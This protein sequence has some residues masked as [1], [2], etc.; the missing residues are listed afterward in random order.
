[1]KKWLLR[2][3]FVLIVIALAIIITG[4]LYISNQSPDY[5]EQLTFSELSEPVHVYYDEYAIPHIYANEI[6][7][8]YLAFGYI[9]AKDR[10]WQMELLR[11]IAPG[12]LSE[13]FGTRMIETDKFFRILGIHDQSIREANDFY[14]RSE[15]DLRRL[16]E[17]YIKG[18]NLFMENGNRPVEYRILG[19]DVEPFS[20][21]DIYNIMGYM[22]FSFSVAH[23]TE[24]IADF[25][26]Q[27]LGTE[28]L[29]ELDLHIDSTTTLI[30]S[31]I[32]ADYSKLSMHVEDIKSELPVPELIGS[33]SWVIGPEKSRTGS[34]L[35][36]N[37]PHIG[38]S[39]PSVWYEAHIIAPGYEVYGNHIAGFPIAQI[40]HN[41]H[42]AIGLTMF[43]N[44]D[45]DY[46]RETINPENPDEYWFD[47]SWRAIEVKS[48]KIAV[49][50]EAPVAFDIRSTHHGPIISDV[51]KHLDA[52]EAISM[53]WVYKKLP[54]RL[55]EASYQIITGNTIEEVRKGASMIH[56][57]GLNV[58]YGDTEGNIAWWASARLPIR[59]AHVNSKLILDGSSGEDEITEYYSFDLNPQAINPSSGFVYSANNQ[60]V[61]TTG[62]RYPG[63]YLPEDRARRIVQLLS[64]KNDWTID[65]VKQMQLD[66]VSNNVVEVVSSIKSALATEDLSPLARRGLDILSEWNGSYDLQQVAPTI[67]TKIIFHIMSGM[68]EDELKERWK[69][70]NGTFLMKR[71]IQ[72]MIAN[73]DSPWWD[74]TDTEDVERRSQIISSA[75]ETTMNEIVDQLGDA[76][77][78]WQWAEVHTLE[79]K[80]TFDAVPFLKN[81]FNVGP[82]PISGSSEV[83]NNTQFTTSADGTYEVGGGPSCRRAI[84]MTK[85]ESESWN[86]LPTGQS[87]NVFSP[88][89]KD[90]VEM[91]VNGQFRRQLMNQQEI[92]ENHKYHT[93]LRPTD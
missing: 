74:N 79:S 80:H 89:Y 22:S 7:D 84:E 63:Y 38:Y 87:G 37:D 72:P 4:A 83:I 69:T 46:Y 45:V 82:F 67:Y 77:D 17:S 16:V 68:M 8:A 19:V 42:H 50:D 40:G 23:K 18:V 76:T 60:S 71:S 14:Q 9:H 47:G 73:A 91:Y 54:L 36:A 26:F 57:P 24:P 32:G 49:K 88:H 30:R 5:N 75:L 55:L 66:V 52:S 90:Q 29:N 85:L 58:M 43:E 1:M 92:F 34:V 21:T 13:I 81:Y 25:I 6:S 61:G 3:F 2:I 11:R 12:R 33:N 70:F 10:L 93:Q 62:I 20:L 41:R 28:Y 53:Y 39:Q 48:S 15:G 31:D 27:Q 44:D 86:I 35:F 56:A 78:N 65:D 59:P 64:E 51:V